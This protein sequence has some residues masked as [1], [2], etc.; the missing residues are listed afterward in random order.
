L[1]IA[2]LIV[3]CQRTLMPGLGSETSTS[4]P[5]SC[6]TGTDADQAQLLRPEGLLI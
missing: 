6:W 4:R 5:T 3:T 1:A 2:L